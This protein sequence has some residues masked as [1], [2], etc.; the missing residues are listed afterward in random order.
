MRV[1]LPHEAGRETVVRIHCAL[2]KRIAQGQRR[3]EI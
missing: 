3:G 1:T 2:A